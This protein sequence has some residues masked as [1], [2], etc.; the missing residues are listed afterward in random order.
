MATVRVHVG[1]MA[2]VSALL[3]IVRFFDYEIQAHVYQGQTYYIMQPTDLFYNDHYQLWYRMVLMNVMRKV[4]PL[5]VATVL[6]SCLVKKLSK[7]SRDKMR[8][9]PAHNHPE[10]RTGT[11]SYGVTRTLILIS[12]LTIVLH[13]PAAIYPFI[14]VCLG[15]IPSDPCAHFYHYFTTCAEAL[16][17]LNSALNF[18]I[19]Y[20]SMPTLRAQLSTM[21]SNTLR[22]RHIVDNNNRVSVVSRKLSVRAIDV[23]N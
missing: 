19:Y 12:V 20:P 2:A 17:A 1:V 7:L 8:F 22:L 4:V 16:A 10:E 18:Y 11:K 14:S 9:F 13:T 15:D 23:A 3:E 5:V 6:T 21:I